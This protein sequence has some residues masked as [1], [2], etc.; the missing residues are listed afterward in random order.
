MNSKTLSPADADLHAVDI[1]TRRKQQAPL[2][3]ALHI[4]AQK[5]ALWDRL[6]ET[7]VHEHVV[8]VGYAGTSSLCSVCNLI[9][10]AREL[11]K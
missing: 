5:L 6:V 9:Q 4:E 11:Q 10:S 8:K 7:L 3:S 1:E 2:R